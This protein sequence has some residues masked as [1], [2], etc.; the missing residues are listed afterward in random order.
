MNTQTLPSGV[1]NNPLLKK[2]L[3]FAHSDDKDKADVISI[4]SG[5][6]ELGQGIEIAMQ[7]IA[8]DALGVDLDQ[9][10]FVTADTHLSPNEM[11]TAGS[12]SI[13][14]GGSALRSA[15]RFAHFMF[16]KAAENYLQVASGSIQ[17]QSGVFS[18]ALTQKTCTY[19]NL[20]DMVN[21][22][23]DV[24]WVDSLPLKTNYVGKST[25]RT[26]LIKKL[27]GNAFI[28]DLTLKNMIHGRVIRGQ[29][30]ESK[31]INIDRAQIEQ[32]E[33][34]DQVVHSG[35][36]LALL[37]YNEAKLVQALKKARNFVEFEAANF[38]VHLDIEELLTS[39]PAESSIV[40]DEGAPTQTQHSHQARFSRPY[41]AHASIGPACALA[42]MQEGLLTVWSH[43]Q[44][45]YPLRSQLAQAFK[46]DE[47]AVE[48]I[49]A[50]GSGC[51]GHN[52]A[53]DVAFDAAFIA[54]QSGLSVRIQWMR[55]DE[56]TASPFGS[57][58]LIEMN[59]GVDA[60]NKISN[61]SVDIWSHSHLNRPGSVPGVNLLGAWQ[62]EDAWP[63]PIS[64]DLPLPTGGGH[65]NAVA[66]YDL[67]QQKINYHFIEKSPLRTSALRSLGSYLNIFAIESFM[68]ELAEKSGVDPVEF[69]INHLKDQRAI[70]VINKVV[71]AS[72]YY[73]QSLA[74]GTQGL[75][76]GFGR[77]KN[78]A[79]YCAVIA[80]INVTEKIQVE[81]IWAAVDVG[82]I[83]NPDGLKNQIEGGII[84]AISWTLKEQVQ[85][86]DTG[87]TTYDWD[88]YPILNFDEV[89]EIELH[90]IEQ[91]DQPSLGAGEIAAGPVPAAIGN[92]LAHAIGIR[93]RHLPLSPDRL[94][95][96]IMNA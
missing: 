67:V 19:W 87:I 7:Q 32:L 26:D 81:K 78:T 53:D 71:Q 86:N 27:S 1:R 35:S 40:F 30:G 18:S 39:I 96:L 4:Y 8:A 17:T 68:N 10:R 83:V 69:R 49:H 70:A 36:F 59:A 76:I 29:I 92:A 25:L 13:D 14:Q 79:G 94:T 75:G 50:P 21:L 33:G 60:N 58:G 11:H 85:W 90:L 23:Q 51:Y 20:A 63:R 43:S 15:C 65:R 34:V 89:P 41:L 9:I 6:V 74:E 2:W 64:Q 55:E 46:L 16:L 47:S 48:V 61:W 52:G 24:Q 73:N 72:N 42:I 12:M 54:I 62:I 22:N 93:A 84:Q 82:L 44:G 37:G 38:P 80:L 91:P 95:Q 31:L 28:Q 57:A 77:Y 45:I 56:M 66:I 3:S 5:K 88:T